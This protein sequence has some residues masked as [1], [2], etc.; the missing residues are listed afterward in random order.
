MNVYHELIVLLLHRM[1]NLEKLSLYLIVHDKN[2]FVDGNDL[3][4]NIINNM[5]RLNLFLF[6]ICSNIRI[7]NQINL[8]SNEYIQ[9]TFKDF[10]N[11][12]NIYCVDHFFEAERSQCHIYSYPYTLKLYKNIT[13]NFSGGF[14]KFVCVVSLFDE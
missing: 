12:H 3:K 5:L 13:N 1:L 14:F 4:K 6:N 9:C 7:H 10:Q 8:P 11:N 2:T